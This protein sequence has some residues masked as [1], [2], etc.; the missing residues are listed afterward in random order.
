MKANIEEYQNNCRQ[1]KRNYGKTIRNHK[2]VK[3]RNWNFKRKKIMK[4]TVVILILVIIVAIVVY[5]FL[6]KKKTGKKQPVIE[7]KQPEINTFPKDEPVS[8]NPHLFTYIV[9]KG[10]SLSKIAIKYNI[11]LKELIRLNPHIKNINLIYPGQKIFVPLIQKKK[12]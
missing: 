11:P 2:K 6:K 1:L 10:D 12:N 5:M 8:H 4:K 3:K 7:K 9:K